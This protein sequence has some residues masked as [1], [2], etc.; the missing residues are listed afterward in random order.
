M[1]VSFKL[2][3]FERQTDVSFR[4]MKI[5]PKKKQRLKIRKES[6]VNV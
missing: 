1:P 5:N 2:A 3:D 4:I 6:R